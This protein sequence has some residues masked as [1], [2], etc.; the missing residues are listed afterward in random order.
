MVLVLMSLA[1][2]RSYIKPLPRPVITILPDVTQIQYVS[3]ALY[4]GDHNQLLILEDNPQ[5]IKARV[6][7][8]T[9]IDLFDSDKLKFR[10]YPAFFQGVVISKKINLGENI[11]AGETKEIV[12]YLPVY[13]CPGPY[14]VTVDLLRNRGSLAGYEVGADKFYIRKKYESL[15]YT[16]LSVRVATACLMRDLLTGGYYE[17]VKLSLT[18]TYSPLNT[19]LESYL[20]WLSGNAE[21]TRNHAEGEGAGITGLIMAAEAF[22][23]S[24]QKTGDRDDYARFQAAEKLV[25]YGLD[26]FSNNRQLDTGGCI[27][28]AHQLS[29]ELYGEDL[30]DAQ[31]NTILSI[32]KE[33]Y[34][35]DPRFKKFRQVNMYDAK[36][37]GEIAQQ[38][39]NV[40][41]LSYNLEQM[42]EMLK[43]WAR[44]IIYFNSLGEGEASY[45]EKSYN[46]G[47]KAVEFLTTYGLMNV[48]GHQDILYGAMDVVIE[49]TEKILYRP[50]YYSIKENGKPEKKKYA[51]EYLEG[52]TDTNQVP[53]EAT[54][55]EAV[56]K[57][58][59]TLHRY[60]SQAPRALAGMA[61]FVYA[62]QM[63][64][65]DVPDDYWIVIE[66]TVDWIICKMKHDPKN[67]F[68]WQSRDTGA[69]P[70]E[71]V[72]G[73]IYAGEALFAVYLAAEK[74]GKFVLADKAKSW[75]LNAYHYVTDDCDYFSHFPGQKYTPDIP[76]D[77]P[78][79]LGYF[80]WLFTEYLEVEF[81]Q[82]LSDWKGWIREEYEKKYPEGMDI[83]GGEET[84]GQ[85]A[86]KCDGILFVA[87]AAYFAFE[88]MDEI[89][90]GDYYVIEYIGE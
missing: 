44:A 42:G 48:D 55:P 29:V 84:L 67:L 83:F 64:N 69:F 62:M 85:R 6:V 58:K 2:V 20:Y 12:R 52:G 68:Q 49:D 38:I 54:Y 76:A 32:G 23:K 57:V 40:L 21:R 16:C 14:L 19:A 24:Y 51:L 45:V 34:K 73:N 71:N 65:K 18:H 81:D 37:K 70:E 50:H 26:D 77:N 75:A 72:L 39:Y 25:K 63:L 36:G 27:T 17:K 88:L 28:L 53:L 80:S 31:G 4:L 78:W 8:K 74:A 41:P 3:I 15:A 90:E 11:P 82:S 56:T 47:R 5:K 61:W 33:P 60:D 22:R 89:E 30:K 86:V 79:T 1:V 59:V 13:L 87:N 66:H 35:S 7:I 10:F 43:P 9:K 46:S